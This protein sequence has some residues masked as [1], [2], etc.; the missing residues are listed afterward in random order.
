MY[1]S[2]SGVYKIGITQTIIFIFISCMGLTRQVMNMLV[3]T[4][5]LIPL[6]STQRYINGCICYNY[7]QGIPSGRCAVAAGEST[8]ISRQTKALFRVVCGKTMNWRGIKH[9][10]LHF[11]RFL[12]RLSVQSPSQ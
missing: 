3:Y 8:C 5:W 4:L 7:S 10:A 6:A 9:A 2:Y 12:G 11:E 1:L